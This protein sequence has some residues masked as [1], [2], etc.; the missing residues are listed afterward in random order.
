MSFSQASVNQLFDSIQSTC[1][2]LGVFD[3]VNTHEPKSAPQKGVTASIWVDSIVPNGRASGLDATSGV[4]TFNVRCYTSMLAQPYD[5]IDPNL[6]TAAMTVLNAFSED[7]TFGETVRDIDLLG[8]YG[9][10]MNARAGYLSIDNKMFRIITV[11]VPV[12]INDLFTQEALIFSKTGGLGDNFYIGGYDLSGDIASLDQI[13]GPMTPFDVTPINAS[14]NV[15]IGGL[16]SGDLQFTSFFDAA[17]GQEHVALSTLPTTDVIATYCRGTVLQNPAACIHG[18]QIN[19]DPTR[20]NTGNLTLKV[21]VQSDSYGLEWGEQLTAGLRTDGSATVG[22][23]ITDTA[24]S[25]YGGQ[26]YFQLVSFTGTSVTIDI[27]SA[28]SSGGSYS[29]TGLTTTAMNAV[30]SQRLATA[31]NLTINQYLKVVTTGTFSNAVFNVVFIRNATA[32]QVF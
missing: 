7:F 28:T 10:S 25:N 21:E 32:G 18:R 3:S 26:A 8:M 23:A 5:Y 27:Q 11:T 9:V 2:T 29:S 30:G 24:A 14:A 17:A 12:V 6:T 20:D 13:S 31:N 16:R 19:Y 15:R 22:S 4:V 1:L